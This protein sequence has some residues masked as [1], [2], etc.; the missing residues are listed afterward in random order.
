MAGNP[1]LAVSFIMNVVAVFWFLAAV[2]LVLVI[3]I[4]KGKGGGLSGAFGGGMASN[5]LG[6]KTGDFLTWFTVSLVGI[7]LVLSVVM[8]KFYKPSMSR[9]GNVPAAVQQQQPAGGQGVQGMPPQPATD[10][11]LP[12]DQAMLDTNSAG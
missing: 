10:E 7:F 2:V 5:I 3:L 11:P 8:V 12:L 6:S 4:Q 9:F 1:L